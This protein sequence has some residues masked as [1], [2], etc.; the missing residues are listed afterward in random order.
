MV[1][2]SLNGPVIRTLLF[3]FISCI[4]VASFSQSKLDTVRHSKW[5]KK[6]GA[7]KNFK[8][9]LKTISKSPPGNATVLNEKS[10][11]LYGTYTGKIIRKIIVNHL[12]FE[13][14]VLDTTRRRESFISRTA[15]N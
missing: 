4:A 8:K 5:V 3:L 13:K 11:E 6:V 12:G 1:T 14:T 2:L 7:N 15:N 10:E 9:L